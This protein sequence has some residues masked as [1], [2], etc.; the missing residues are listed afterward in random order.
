MIWTL[1]LLTNQVTKDDK[2]P[3]SAPCGIDLSSGELA[4][5]RFMQLAFDTIE[6]T[7]WNLILLFTRRYVLV[8][9]LIAY[10]VQSDNLLCNLYKYF[11]RFIRINNSIID[12]PSHKATRRVKKTD[13]RTEV[14]RYLLVKKLLK[15]VKGFEWRT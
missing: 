9:L 5:V 4:L 12:I 10:C 1:I 3:T 13:D 15:L 14:C 2:K 8:L 7:L 11:K 6:W